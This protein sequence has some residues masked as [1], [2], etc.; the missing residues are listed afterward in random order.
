[1]KFAVNLACLSDGAT[2]ET[3]YDEPYDDD[4]T[5]VDTESF[6]AGMKPGDTAVE[7]SV[8]HIY[9]G[10]FTVE[11]IVRMRPGTVEPSPATSWEENE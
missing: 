3:M 8:V 11:L 9:R 10:A 6:V 1:M 5:F 4:P 2:D 7:A